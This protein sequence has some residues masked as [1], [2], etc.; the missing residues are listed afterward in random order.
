MKKNRNI[1]SSSTSVPAITKARNFN[2]TEINPLEA[3]V[4]RKWNEKAAAGAF[5]KITYNEY[6]KRLIEFGLPEERWSAGQCF[7]RNKKKNEIGFN[8]IINKG[9]NLMAIDRIDD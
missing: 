8:S 1:V 3:V 2:G 9:C 6:R 7:D 5:D 4:A